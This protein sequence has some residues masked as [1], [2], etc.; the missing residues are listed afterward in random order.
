[1]KYESMQHSF[2]TYILRNTFWWW[3]RTVCEISK[4]ATLFWE[5]H[6]DDGGEQFV[7]KYQSMQHSSPTPLCVASVSARNLL[8]LITHDFKTFY[9][10]YNFYNFKTFIIFFN[11]FQSNFIK[12]C[13][14]RVCTQP[15]FVD[16]T[17]FW[18]RYSHSLFTPSTDYKVRRLKVSRLLEIA[19]QLFKSWT[20]AEKTRQYHHL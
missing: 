9:N 14:K 18:N 5:I 19:R 1:M 16:K 11:F 2:K 6:F 13:L 7:K 12:S 4:H 20:N 17:R 15:A 3:W 10:F 8:L